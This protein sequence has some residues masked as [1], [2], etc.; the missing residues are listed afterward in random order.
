VAAPAEE[1]A[2]AAAAAAQGARFAA[3]QTLTYAAAC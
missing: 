2:E 1:E 3:L